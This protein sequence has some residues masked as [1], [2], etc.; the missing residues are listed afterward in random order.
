MH[1]LLLYG[2]VPNARLEQVLQVLA[3]VAAM[4]PQLVY[5]RHL[6]Y[7]QKSS[8][9]AQRQ[10]KKFPNR[11]IK[12]PTLLV[13][14]L[15]RELDEDDFGEESPVKPASGDDE[16]A[17]PWIL[18]AADVPEP[19]TKAFIVRRA[20]EAKLVEEKWQQLQNP[21]VFT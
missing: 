14:H 20:T 12:P 11:Q 4:K 9:E 17:A 5:E 3:G 8:P 1:E 15:Q 16:A 21:A 2:Q 7:R 10:S 19:E 6:M 13:H 18:R